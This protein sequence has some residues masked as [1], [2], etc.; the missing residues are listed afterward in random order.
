MSAEDRYARF[1][2]ERAQ[3]PPLMSGDTFHWDGRGA[4][5]RSVGRMHVSEP[6]GCAACLALPL[7]A[8]YRASPAVST[9]PMCFILPTPVP[10][11]DWAKEASRLTLY[12]D[13]ELL[14]APLHTRLP[15]TTG[16]LMWVHGH[17]ECLT[18]SVHPALLVHTAHTSLQVECA[19]LVL[20]LSIHDPLHYHIAMVLEAAVDAEGE[21]GQLYAEAL[22]DALAVHFLRRYAAAQPVRREVTCGLTPYKLRRTLAYIQAHL[23]E[24]ISLVQLAAVAQMSPTY[25]GHMFKQAT[26]LAPHQYVSLCRI[27]HAK[28]LLAETDMPLIEISTQ[29]GCADQSH[30]TALFRRYVAMTPNAY[31]STTR[32]PFHKSCTSLLLPRQREELRACSPHA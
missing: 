13:P 32:D 11:I 24:K 1:A 19:E 9:R 18:P 16:D 2:V 26:G 3:P 17:E 12:L 14:L 8:G 15:G 10:A 20:H 4:A 22:A 23:E 5:S 30:F 27:E 28:R 7:G 31:R 21:A 6:T 25:F 29:V